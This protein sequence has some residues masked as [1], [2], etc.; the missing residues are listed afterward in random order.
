MAQKQRKE[1]N[2]KQQIEDYRRQGTDT[3][4]GEQL[5]R[6]R[7]KDGKKQRKRRTRKR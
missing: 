3:R 2:R 1:R 5:D 7:A 6:E 4:L